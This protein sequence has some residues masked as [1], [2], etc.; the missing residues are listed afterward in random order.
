MARSSVCARE[1]VVAI[2][3]IPQPFVRNGAGLSNQNNAL[4]VRRHRNID[5]D[6]TVRFNN[7]KVTVSALRRDISATFRFRWCRRLCPTDPLNRSGQAEADKRNER[8]S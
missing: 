8:R 3:P 7:P 1:V 4:K 5:A 6:S 2:P